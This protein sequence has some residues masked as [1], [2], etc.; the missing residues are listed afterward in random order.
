MI[1]LTGARSGRL[2]AISR[3]PS[4]DRRSRWLC[5]CDCGSELVVL[6]QSL[7]DGNTRSC[8]CLRAELLRQL[9]RAPAE[10]ID[11][12]DPIAQLARWLAY[13][14]DT[15]VITWKVARG[16]VTAGAVA[17]AANGAGYRTVR[18]GRIYLEHRLAFVLMD[19]RWP[20]AHVDHINGDK[21]DNR[22][23]NLREASPRLNAENKRRAT[24]ANK[25]GALGVTKSGSG[26][27]A[28]IG[29]RGHKH[30]LGVFAT[31]EDAHA[32]YVD[33][34]RRLHEGCT[35]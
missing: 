18:A 32:A 16:R 31:A 8:G 26:F 34:K 7:R 35:L 3:E 10:S 33:A 5:R 20:A 22:W 29:S 21:S 11:A 9:R 28:S 4:T 14:P 13:D 17:G 30:H 1:D 12:V 27:A 25:V 23:A 15:G 19:G 24:R 2:T 6:A